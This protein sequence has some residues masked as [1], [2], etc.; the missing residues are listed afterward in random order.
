MSD[1]AI[2]QY[3]L[4]GLST[5]NPTFSNGRTV[6]DI[7]RMVMFLVVPILLNHLKDDDILLLTMASVLGPNKKK[8]KNK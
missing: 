5:V 1:K 6:C 7:E 3:G 4:L 2:M 8:K